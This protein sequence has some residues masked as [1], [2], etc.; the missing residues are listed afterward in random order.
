MQP[1]VYITCAVTGGGPMAKSAPPGFPKSNQEVALS[2]LDAAAAGAAIIHIHVRKPDGKAST[3]FED[4]N[5]TVSL[6][7]KKN[8]DVILNLTTGPGCGWRQSDDDPRMPAPGTNTMTA[9]RR[10]EHVMKLKEELA[11]LDVCTMQFGVNNV[12]INTHKMISRML[13]MYKDAGVKPE[14]ECFDTGDIMFAHDLIDEGILEGPGMYSF[15]LGGKYGLHATT[16]AMM[17]CRSLMRPGAVWAGFGVSRHSFP[18]AAQ[19]VILGGNV[20]VGFED[21]MYLAKG[22]VAPTNASMVVQARELVER[23]GSTVAT[24]GETR[25]ILGLSEH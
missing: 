19:S 17:Y 11:T 21:T 8:T 5:E 7:R 25:K 18:M 6:I 15:V 13:G 12:A 22:K 14:V 16:E 23:L 4:Y 10:C 2:A 9:E 1:K 20:R 3:D 24:P